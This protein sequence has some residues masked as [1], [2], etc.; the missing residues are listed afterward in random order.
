MSRA[1]RAVSY[2][3]ERTT[4]F[5]GRQQAAKPAVAAPVQLVVRRID[6]DPVKRDVAHHS[7]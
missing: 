7:A 4:Q 1:R 5:T 2:E 6:H 3:A